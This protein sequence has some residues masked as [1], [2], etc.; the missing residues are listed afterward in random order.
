MSSTNRY[1]LGYVFE[2]TEGT[3]PIDSADW[4]TLRI[5]SN[6]VREQFQFAQSQEIV[7]NRQRTGQKLVGSQV[8]GQI[9]VELSEDSFDPLIEALT[10]GTW[11]TNVLKCGSTERS[12]SLEGYFSDL[13][14]YLWVSGV[15]I[16]SGNFTFQRG[17]PALFTMDVVGKI[18][19]S[20][21]TGQSLVGTGSQAAAATTEFLAGVDISSIKIA[22]VETTLLVPEIT[23]SITNNMYPLGDLRTRGPSRHG[24]GFS[25]VTG[26]MTAYL[27]VDGA[28]DGLA[29]YDRVAAG[30]THDLQFRITLGSAFFDFD[31]PTAKLTDAPIEIQGGNQEIMPVYPFQAFDPARTGDQLIITRNA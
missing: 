14:E 17:Q 23:L 25:D 11:A 10:Q 3:T 2:T 18:S 26:T 27:G 6:T 16:N 12:L 7:A 5:R 13:D 24:S 19:G 29:L 9:V 21:N 22:N 15:K 28:A 31:L 8:A 30:T 20:N 1:S 4:G